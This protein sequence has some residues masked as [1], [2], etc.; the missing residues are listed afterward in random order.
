MAKAY[1]DMTVAELNTANMLLQEK[2]AKVFAEV[3][4]EQMKVQAMLDV[5]IPQENE[6]AATVVVSPEE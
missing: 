3:E 5:K 6:A 4:A 1:E 2:R